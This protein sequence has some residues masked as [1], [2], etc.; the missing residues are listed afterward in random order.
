MVKSRTPKSKKKKKSHDPRWL[1]Y[2]KLAA[3]IYAQLEPYAK[4]THDD[5]IIGLETGNERQIDVS[6]RYKIA[7]H[8]ILLII[9]A[10][11]YIRRVDETKVGEFLSVIQDVLSPPVRNYR[12]FAG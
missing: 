4:V 12:Y 10:K 3:A 5:K 9:Q 11:N 2:Q 7:G 8:E 6:I 1:R